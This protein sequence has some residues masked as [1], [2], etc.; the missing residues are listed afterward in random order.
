MLPVPTMH[1]TAPPLEVIPLPSPV[2]S[3]AAVEFDFEVSSDAQLAYREL[4]GSDKGKSYKGKD[5]H[6]AEAAKCC[7]VA[8]SPDRQEEYHTG[9]VLICKRRQ[10]E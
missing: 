9:T 1:S 6:N 10:M 7:V 5:G 3:N 8:D 4:E 2:S